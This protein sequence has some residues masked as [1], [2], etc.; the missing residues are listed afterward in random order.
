M[1]RW[2]RRCGSAARASRRSPAWPCSSRTRFCPRRGRS[3]PSSGPYKRE[4]FSRPADGPLPV[5]R[6]V[7]TPPEAKGEAL[8]T[9]ADLKFSTGQTFA[10]GGED[11]AQDLLHAFLKGKIGGYDVGRDILAEDRTSL[12][13]RHLHLGTMSARFVVDAVRRAGKDKPSG[14][15]PGEHAPEPGHSTFLSEI[16]WHDFY[17]QIL[18]HFPH[19]ATGAFRPQFNAL[20]WENDERLFAA[21]KEGRTGYPIVD[22]AM[23]QMNSEAWMHNRGRM[24]VASFLTKDLLI[25]WRWG[26]KYFMRQL[27]DG[28][29]AAN[30][31]GWQWAAGTGTDAQ[32]FF[33]IFN[34]TSQ[35]EKFDPDGVYVKR[36]VPEL[37]RVPVKSIHAPWK[38]TAAEREHLGC[39][40]YPAPIVDH[41][42]RRQ[43][44]LAMYG[45]VTTGAAEKKESE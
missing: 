7:P 11:A 38:L 35:G 26:E 15:T 33:R 5:P 23:R 9:A 21:W 19:V 30:N 32:P 3:I 27:V 4:W 37:A 1:R 10:S 22:A 36:W 25:D 16:A 45:K 28:D 17:L 14:G 31:G 24:V 34:P 44:A 42:A 12:L 39:S 13:S 8:P 40:E 2:R 18:H 6:H 20:E 41:A 29:Q 43:R